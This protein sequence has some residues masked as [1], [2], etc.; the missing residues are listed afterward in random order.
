MYFLRPR[1]SDKVQISL[2]CEQEIIARHN[3]SLMEWVIENI[4]KN[5]VDAMEGKGLLEITA[6]ATPG[7]V[8]IDIRDNGKGISPNR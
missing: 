2:N 6:H 3:P 1:I 4:V 7:W 5:A 8:N